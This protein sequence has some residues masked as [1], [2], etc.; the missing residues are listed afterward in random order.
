MIIWPVSCCE[1]NFSKDRNK[2]KVGDARSPEKRLG[3]AS[4]AAA[5]ETA[6][7]MGIG[8]ERRKRKLGE[9]LEGNLV[10]HGSWQVGLNRDKFATGHS[11]KHPVARQYFSVRCPEPN[12]SGRR[13]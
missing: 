4:P 13:I 2:L 5:V 1:A 3:A 11:H 12:T 10:T 8:T 9:G 7:R 6:Q